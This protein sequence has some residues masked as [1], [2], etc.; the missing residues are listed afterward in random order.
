MRLASAQTP[1]P[2]S[3]G[4]LIDVQRDDDGRTTIF[5]GDVSGNGEAAASIAGRTR[6]LVRRHLLS[7][8]SLP[9][10]FASLNDAL[11]ATLAPDIFM[12]AVAARIDARF[13]SLEVVSAGHLG[14]LVRRARGGSRA[15]G[16]RPGPPLGLVRNQQFPAVTSF[17]L[18]PDDTIVFATDGV[19][20]RFVTR[21]DHHGQT[22]LL[23]ELAALPL[24][25]SSLCRRLLGTAGGAHCDA[26]VL[27]VQFGAG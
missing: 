20:D 17:D 4:D 25:P 13:G 9:A 27:A 26:T 7:W 6:R 18:E 12:T 21:R 23:G 8:V 11:E 15:L 19:T 1:G 10:G 5:L 2:G 14:P 24:G 3:T 22:G 16:T